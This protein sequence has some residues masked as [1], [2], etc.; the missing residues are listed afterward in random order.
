MGEGLVLPARPG[1][2]RRRGH[3]AVEARVLELDGGATLRRFHIVSAAE[4]RGRVQVQ[5]MRGLARHDVHPAIGHLQPAVREVE[6]QL[7]RE[8]LHMPVNAP[9]QLGERGGELVQLVQRAVSREAAGVILLRP[10]L[11]GA[12]EVAELISL[13]EQLRAEP[14]RARAEQRRAVDERREPSFDAHART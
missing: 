14:R 6:V 10:L 12:V 7:A 1:L 4:G 9:L 3:E 13:L 2:A 5:A 8:R 11:A